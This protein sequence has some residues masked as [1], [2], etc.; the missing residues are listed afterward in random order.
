MRLACAHI[1]IAAVES[2][3]CVSASSCTPNVITMSH[4]VRAA[5]TT[6]CVRRLSICI[7][8]GPVPLLAAT[9]VSRHHRQRACVRTYRCGD[10]GHEP[11]CL[12]Q[13]RLWKP[14]RN[15]GP[16]QRAELIEC[17]ITGVPILFAFLV[18]ERDQEPIYDGL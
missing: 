10:P 11:S 5:F 13:R 12:R 17:G 1:F 14:L 16:Q 15:A 8:P 7:H 2:W 9:A 6:S 18:L 4:A 3:S